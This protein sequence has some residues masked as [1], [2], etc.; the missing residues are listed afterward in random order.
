MQHTVYFAHLYPCYKRHAFFHD[1]SILKKSFE[2]DISDLSKHDVYKSLK[3]PSEYI[4]SLV[5]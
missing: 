3:Q 2:L 5:F 1:L 4:S